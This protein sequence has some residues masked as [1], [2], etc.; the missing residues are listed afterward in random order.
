MRRRDLLAAFAGAVLALS[1]VAT[2]V[3]GPGVLARAHAQTQAKTQDITRD[4]IRFR[5]LAI[6]AALA[7]VAVDG[8]RTAMAHNDTAD[9]VADL[10][11]RLSALEKR[12]AELEKK[13]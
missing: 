4:E 6:A 12:L 9:R 8:E 10:A 2:G 5:V 11:E 1:A 3:Y 13:R 7:S